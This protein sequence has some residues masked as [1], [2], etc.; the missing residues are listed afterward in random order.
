MLSHSEARNLRSSSDVEGMDRFMLCWRCV[1]VIEGVS[2][3]H[4]VKRLTSLRILKCK[5]HAWGFFSLRYMFL[6]APTQNVQFSAMEFLRRVHYLIVFQ[7]NWNVAQWS[8]GCLQRRKTIAIENKELQFSVISSNICTLLRKMPQNRF[9]WEVQFI[10]LT[11]GIS[12]RAVWNAQPSGCLP[13]A[14]SI[15]CLFKTNFLI[16]SQDDSCL[17]IR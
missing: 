9:K 5:V 2:E 16:L 12:L 17:L 1:C 14:I 3:V 6:A 10:W 11:L 15:Y 8:F 13:I 4:C 7:L